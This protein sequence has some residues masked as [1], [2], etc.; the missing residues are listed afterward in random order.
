MKKKKLRPTKLNKPTGIPLA[1]VSV[2]GGICMLEKTLK[3]TGNSLFL[4]WSTDGL[5]FSSDKKKV[6]ISITGRK[7]EKI[8]ECINFSLS[9]TPTGFIMTYIR[10]GKTRD[11]DFFVIAKSRD[12]NSWIVKSQITRGDSNHATVVYDKL[13]DLFILYKDGLFAKSQ[14]T[15]TL[16]SWKEGHTLLFT[17]RLGM[18][19]SEHISIIG[20]LDTKEGLL[21]IYDASV[22]K[23]LQT[24]IQIGGIL[25]DNNDPRRI[26]W[27]SEAPLWQGVVELEG[28]K[29]KIASAGFVYFQGTFQVYWTTLSGELVLSTF[30]SLFKNTEIYQYNILEKFDEN[31]II[32][33][34]IEHGWEV[35]GTFNPAVFQDEDGLHMFYRA[36]GDDGI[37]RIGYAHSKDGM[38]FNKRLSHP[39]FEPYPGV[40]MPLIKTASGPIGFHPAF[41]TS[42]GGWGGSE[43][44]RVVKIDGNIYMTYVA[45]EGW[46]SVR[47]A[48]TSISVTDFK[49]GKWKWKKPTLISPKGEVHKN[50]VLF[51]EK[52]NGKFAV[53]HGV[54]PNILVDYLDSFDD[55]DDSKCIKS[56]P[57]SGGRE[58]HWDNRMRG[59]GP[60]PIKTDL[61]WLLFYHAQDKQEPNKYKLGAMILDL[62]NPTKILYRSEHPILYPEMHYENT[63]KPGVIYASGAVI[64]DEELRIYYGGGDRVIC[65]ASTPVKEFLHYLQTG[66]PSSYELKKVSTRL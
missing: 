62:N 9:S 63:G 57:P 2:N 23:G 28:K 15:R 60:P 17:S 13:L 47:M 30:P 59:A 55:T 4:S 45:F 52:I 21:V 8:D 36:L 20:S 7:K 50:W 6:D 14:Q 64:K 29:D 3:K 44:P 25:F 51:P 1:T 34:R 46:G 32:E 53:L 10:Q 31:P 16:V 19:D 12:L 56:K 40:G 61:G 65:I 26:V 49:S 35:L 22:K 42:G 39:V 37:S 41:Y 18:F 54:S 43:D 66:N 27:R 58:T 11:K 48:V 5:N 24:L 33:P 38:H